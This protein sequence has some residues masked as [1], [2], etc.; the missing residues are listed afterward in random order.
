M[1]YRQFKIFTKVVQGSR[2]SSHGPLCWYDAQ[3]IAT[4]KTH[5]KFEGPGSNNAKVIAKVKV[6]FPFLISRSNI[7]VNV[8]GWQ[9]MVS[10]AGL[11][12][13]IICVKYENCTIT[14]S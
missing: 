14:G 12:K 2:S 6:F 10:I 11:I 9:M 1:S 7:K 13:R 8:I 4:R 3:A 5:V